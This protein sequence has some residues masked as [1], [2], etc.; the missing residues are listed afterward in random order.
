MCPAFP[1]RT[2]PTLRFYGKI[3]AEKPETVFE[4]RGFFMKRIAKNRPALLALAALM[5]L[6]TVLFPAQA[7]ANAAEPP[8]VI[9]VVL[10]APDDLELSAQVNGEFVP[11][12]ESSAAWERYYKLH[13][14]DYPSAS[15]DDAV[16]ALRA[17]SGGDVAAVELPAAAQGYDNVYTLD[18]TTMTLTE[19]TLPLRSALLIAMRLALTLVLEGLV[20]YLFGFR[21]KR[22]WIAFFIINLITQGAL[23]ILL[24]LSS[25]DGGYLILGLILIEILVFLVET[26]AFLFAVKEKRWWQ[27]LLYVLLANVLSLFLGGVLITYLPV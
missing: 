25:F 6:C 22:S 26:P 23:N 1:L 21:A 3:A 10:N 24:S 13:Y 19:G 8:A 15:R 18:Y 7:S 11:M 2:L 9:V 17:V 4:Q 20:F 16:T 12:S 27:R 5:L 14:F